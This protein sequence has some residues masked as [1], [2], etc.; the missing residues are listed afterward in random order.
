MEC[1]DHEDVEYFGGVN[2]IEFT[3]GGLQG[4]ADPRRT[5]VAAGI[6]QMERATGL[7]PPGFA[8]LGAHQQQI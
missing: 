2:A 1:P 5:N 7:T 8:S 6:E 3:P 4:L